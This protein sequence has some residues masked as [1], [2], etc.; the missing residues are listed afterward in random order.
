M[1]TVYSYDVEWRRIDPNHPRSNNV[2]ET[3]YGVFFLP[4]SDPLKVLPIILKNIE[5]K[6]GA[7]ICVTQF[8]GPNSSRNMFYIPQE[9]A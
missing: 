5:E 7:I 6:W 9:T 1:I 4:N 3:L 2:E 8:R